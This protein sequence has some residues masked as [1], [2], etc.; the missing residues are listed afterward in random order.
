VDELP[1]G[2]MLEVAMEVGFEVGGAT[3]QLQADE[4]RE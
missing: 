4:I 2:A 1:Y 3:T